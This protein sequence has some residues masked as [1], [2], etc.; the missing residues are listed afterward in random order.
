MPVM[1]ADRLGAQTPALVKALT[2][3]MPSLAN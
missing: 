3:R 2:K 1:M